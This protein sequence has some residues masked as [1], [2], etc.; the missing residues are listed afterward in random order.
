MDVFVMPSLYEGLGMVLVEAQAAGLPAVVSNKVPNE[1]KLFDV[2][3]FISLHESADKWADCV[4]SKRG[5]ERVKTSKSAV[6]K[7]S[8]NEN[9]KKLEAV[10]ESL[11]AF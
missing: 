10:Y 6:S 4:L 2:V 11:I 7:F 5:L 9:A 3:D 1:A 8:I